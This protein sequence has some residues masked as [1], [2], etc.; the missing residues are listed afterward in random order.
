MAGVGDLCCV[1]AGCES[2]DVLDPGLWRSLLCE[3]QQERSVP[4]SEDRLN[5]WGRVG[6]VQYVAVAFSSYFI[7]LRK[8]GEFS[9]SADGDGWVSCL[10]L[11]YKDGACLLS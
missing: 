9:G 4:G 11:R 5:C 6:R 10:V 1:W 3:L 7:P 8:A 2:R